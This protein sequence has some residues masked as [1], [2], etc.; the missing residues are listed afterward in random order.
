[1]LRGCVREPGQV[2]PRARWSTHQATCLT[3]QRQHDGRSDPM[4]VATRRTA[5]VLSPRGRVKRRREF[6]DT[7]PAG[8]ST[9]A[10]AFGVQNSG[11]AQWGGRCRVQAPACCAAAALPN[12]RYTTSM[13]TML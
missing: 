12:P 8:A 6:A 4:S 11:V 3:E 1:M 9:T 7:T 10:V 13:E 2:P 5:Q